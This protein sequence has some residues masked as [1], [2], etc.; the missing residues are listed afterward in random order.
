SS[1]LTRTDR[2]LQPHTID[3]F[4]L[5]RNLSKIYSNVTDAKI[6]AEEVLDILKTASNNHELENKLIILLGFEQFEFIKTLR[7]YRQMIL[8]CTLLARAQNTLEK[9][10]IEE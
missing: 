6:K 1:D 9:A 3:A 4:W 7:M 2:T 5:E 8:Y 10:E